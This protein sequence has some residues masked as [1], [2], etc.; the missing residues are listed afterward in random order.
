MG[1]ATAHR[2]WYRCLAKAR[3][4]EHGVTSGDKMH[5]ARHNGGERRLR[6]LWEGDGDGGINGCE[7]AAEN[8]I[9]EPITAIPLSGAANALRM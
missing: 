8:G 2:W 4:V 3:V 6:G 7:I 1:A 9:T 5:K